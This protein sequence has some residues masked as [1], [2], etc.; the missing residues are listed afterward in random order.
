MFCCL[1]LFLFECSSG[2]RAAGDLD[3]LNTTYARIY[4]NEEKLG[5]I[6][7]YGV[8][9]SDTVVFV[10]RAGLKIKSKYKHDAYINVENLKRIDKI[11]NGADR[12]D[13]VYSL[14]DVNKSYKVTVG[15][16]APGE[17]VK[18]CYTYCGFPFYV[19]SKKSFAYLKLNSDTVKN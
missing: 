11:V 19:T 3:S 9:S 2:K 4:H 8:K 18:T 13:F 7:Y 10:A 6:F 12:L 5:Y 14:W 16:G 17:A 1:T 15:G